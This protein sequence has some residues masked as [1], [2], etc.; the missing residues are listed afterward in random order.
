MAFFGQCGD[1]MRTEL[2]VKLSLSG[3]A[4]PS[5]AAWTLTPGRCY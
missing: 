1:C 5:G 4:G 2:E 3:H